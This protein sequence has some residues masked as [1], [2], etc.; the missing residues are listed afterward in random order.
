[1]VLG[2]V[3]RQCVHRARC[4]VVIVGRRQ[5]DTISAGTSGTEG[6]IRPGPSTIESSEETAM[7]STQAA[8]THRIVVGIDGSPTSAA[9]AEWAAHQ[10]ELT[11]ADLEALMTWEWPTTY[12]WSLPVPSG[13]DPADD[14]E[15]LLEQVLEPVREAHPSISIQS[16]VIEGH[17]APLLVKASQGADLLVVGSRGHGGFAG[18]LLGSVSEHCVT[19]AHCP[20]LVLRDRK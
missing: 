3:N 5:H 20:V 12:G 18:M 2:S 15:T 14:S 1:M 6:E 17:P 4:P 16:S 11:G 9:V 8:A 7:T 13:Y 19:N 10:A